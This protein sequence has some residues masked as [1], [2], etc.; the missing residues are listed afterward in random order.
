V[1]GLTKV[2]ELHRE[3]IAELYSQ[4]N[5]YPAELQRG[6]Y[7]LSSDHSNIRPGWH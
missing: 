7:R 5:G 2:D 1:E 4:T 6:M 3:P